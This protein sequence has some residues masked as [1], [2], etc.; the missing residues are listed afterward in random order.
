MV[1]SISSV[2]NLTSPPESYLGRAH[3]Y[4]SWQRI[5]SSAVCAS[6][7]MST[8]NDCS[9][10]AVGTLHLYHFSPLTHRSLIVTFTLTLT[11]LTIL[12]PHKHRLVLY[13]L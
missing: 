12:M 10:S 2:I 11:L 8:T 1:V 5:H 3:Y 6:C 9:Y 13:R 4:S 7:A